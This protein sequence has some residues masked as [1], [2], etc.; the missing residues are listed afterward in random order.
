VQRS[1]DFFDLN[2]LFDAR[3]YRALLVE[4]LKQLQELRN[5]WNPFASFFC[6]EGCPVLPDSCLTPKDLRT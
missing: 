1:A 3:G 5:Q 2:A 6:P 4:T